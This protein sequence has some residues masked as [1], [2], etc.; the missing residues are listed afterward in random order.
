MSNELLKKYITKRVGIEDEKMLNDSVIYNDTDSSYISIKHIIDNTDINF[1]DSEG[2]LT[3]EL[4]DE[5]QCIED[6]LNDEIK[7]WGSKA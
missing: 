6:F 3:K 1:V 7:V 2:N 4:H 5:V